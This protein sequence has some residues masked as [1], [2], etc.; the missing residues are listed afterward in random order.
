MTIKSNSD[1]F[2]YYASSQS[3]PNLEA[4]LHQ[5][6]SASR[7]D[8]GEEM[9]ADQAGRDQSQSNPA[10]LGDD[11]KS[12][13]VGNDEGKGQLMLLDGKHLSLSIEELNAKRLSEL[14]NLLFPR[15]DLNSKNQ[16]A[17]V[18]SFH[19]KTTEVINMERMKNKSTLLSHYFEDGKRRV[20][21]VMVFTKPSNNVNMKSEEL[22]QLEQR[23]IFEVSQCRNP[24]SIGQI[25]FI[26]RDFQL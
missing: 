2:S 8:L 25:C 17:S 22:M 26:D 16:S 23:E 6:L 24:F 13:L 20:D 9:L 12:A 3:L 18:A 19:E 1:L 14:D 15:Q 10:L 5:H 21:Y 11:L 4:T 7:E